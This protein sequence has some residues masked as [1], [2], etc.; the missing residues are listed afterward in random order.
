[1]LLQKLLYES[2]RALG[3]CVVP[4]LRVRVPGRA[5]VM[6]SLLVKWQM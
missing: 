4:P 2:F 6:Y 5:K 1:M 3:E